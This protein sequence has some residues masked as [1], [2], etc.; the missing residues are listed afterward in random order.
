MYTIRW[1]I[2]G[3]VAPERIERTWVGDF[4]RETDYFWILSLQQIPRSSAAGT[5]MDSWAFTSYNWIVAIANAYEGIGLNY[6]PKLPIRLPAFRSPGYPNTLYFDASDAYAT[7]D[8]LLETSLSNKASR[9]ENPLI[10]YPVGAAVRVHNNF[11]VHPNAY[12]EFTS[13]AGAEVEVL[14]MDLGAEYDAEIVGGRLKA[15]IDVAQVGSFV[16]VYISPET[17]AWEEVE[18]TGDLPVV[19]ATEEVKTICWRAIN[20][21]VRYISWRVNSANV[22][23][24][25]TL[26]LFSHFVQV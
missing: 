3:L 18:D 10:T 24:T 9:A 23:R 2:E 16:K 5:V 8:I 19:G 22:A 17:I 13:N 21:T 1:P 26:R 12:D 14:R 11:L 7:M 20:R 15:F 6:D 4:L 25:A